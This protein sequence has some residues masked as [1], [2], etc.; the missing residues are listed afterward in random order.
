MTWD[1]S[2]D[3]QNWQAWNELGDL[4]NRNGMWIMRSMGND[5]YIASPEFD[6][7]SIALGDIEI[8]MSVRADHTPLK[9]LV[10]WVV[11]GQADFSPVYK[12]SFDVQA[13]GEVRT[14]R[15]NVSQSQLLYLGD[16]VRRLRLDPVDAPAEIGMKMIRIWTVCSTAQADRCVCER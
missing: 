13:D 1:F 4:E 11:V 16:R 6:L 5:P 9:G 7:P 15:V 8:T 12:Q 3:L 2:H 10:Y 14:Y